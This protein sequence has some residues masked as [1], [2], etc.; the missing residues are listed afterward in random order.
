MRLTSF[1]AVCCLVVGCSPPVTIDDAGTGGGGGVATGGGGTGGGSGGGNTGGGGGAVTGGGGGGI[2]GGG[3]GSITG[4]GGGTVTGGGGGSI[5]GGG[6]GNTGGG[7]GSVTGGGS[8]TN[9]AGCP[10]TPWEGKELPTDPELPRCQVLIPPFTTGA[11][12]TASSQATFSQA[13]SAAQ[14]GDKI[15]ITQ[16]FTVSGP[17]LLPNKGATTEYITIYSTGWDT[18]PPVALVEN[19]PNAPHVSASTP[20]FTITTTGNGAVEATAGAH[21][22]H[23]VGIEFRVSPSVTTTSGVVRFHC[24]S[25]GSLLSEMPHHL[26]LDRCR[27]RGAGAI[28]GND[29]VRGVILNANWSAVHQSYVD[30]FI[31]NQSDSQGVASW[32]SDGPL[33]V[34]N[35]FIEGGHENVI[36]G[37]GANSRSGTPNDVEVRFNHLYKRAAWLKSGRTKNLFELKYVNRALIEANLMENFTADVQTS[38]VNLKTSNNGGSVAAE[39]QNVTFRYNLFR[40]LDS[41]WMKLGAKDGSG[42]GPEI[43]MHDVL[44]AHN[45]VDGPI[46]VTDSSWFL[47][48]LPAAGYDRIQARNNTGVGSSNTCISIGGGGASAVTLTN[49][50]CSLGM[51][52]VKGPG[53]AAGTASLDLLAGAGNYVFDGNVLI[54]PSS[55]SYPAGNRFVP[56]ISSVGFTSFL[57]DGGSDLTL[58]AS[59]TVRDAGVGGSVP[60][61]DFTSLQ[62]RL[63]GVA[64]VPEVP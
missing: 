29:H 63:Q 7:G 37:G 45:A 38:A 24:G 12:L 39:T 57:P 2:A 33:R 4:G 54:G 51:Y 13:L 58:S 21:H 15:E 20:M 41:G 55:S 60:G 9:D 43:S 6:G 23:F 59:S 31:Q 27:V 53:A 5:T 52:G 19:Q 35:N 25:C 42:G 48:L 44:V 14:P 26:I 16:S 11:H 1:A 64:Y 30:G 61:A 47:Q 34:T 28:G 36:F 8:G 18:S 49:N 10:N 22:F 17:V 50:I 40:H 46:N 62:S 56:Q 3:G 32:Y